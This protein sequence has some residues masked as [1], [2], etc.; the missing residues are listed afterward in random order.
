MT[1]T[2]KLDSALFK[3]MIDSLSALLKEVRLHL[4]EDGLH[5]ISVDSA[6]VAMVVMHVPIGAFAEYQLDEPKAFG[7]DLEKIHA[8]LATMGKGDT[9][10]LSLNEKEKKLNQN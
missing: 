7:L 2:A 8:I 4:E 5:A 6:N 10:T 1:F 9:V 3:A